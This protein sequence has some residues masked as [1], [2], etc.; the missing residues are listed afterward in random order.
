MMRQPIDL[1]A[2]ERMVNLRGQLMTAV[3]DLASVLERDFLG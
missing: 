3:A 2:D 1:A